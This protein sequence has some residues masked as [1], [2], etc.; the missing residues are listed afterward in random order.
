MEMSESKDILFSKDRLHRTRSLATIFREINILQRSCDFNQLTPY[1]A[2]AML[3][4]A[5]S[6]SVFSFS[7]NEEEI[8]HINEDIEARKRGMSI[9]VSL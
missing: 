9:N 8:E 2:S 6:T 7:E 1:L 4:T 5:S 3:L